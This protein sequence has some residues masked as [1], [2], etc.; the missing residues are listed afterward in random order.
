MQSQ[1]KHLL[2]AILLAWI[3]CAVL[4]GQSHKSLRLEVSDADRA[5]LRLQDKAREHTRFS[6]PL[7]LDLA[8]A[9]APDTY[10]FENGEWTWSHTFTVS[11]AT[12]LGLFLDRLDLPVGGHLSLANAYGRKGAFT[13]VDASYKNRLFTDF[14]PGESVTLT[15]RGPLPETVPFRIWRIDH[16]YRPDRWRDPRDKGFGDSN[17]CHVNANCDQGDGWDDEQSGAARINLVVTEGV[18]FCSGSLINNTAMDGRPFLLTGFHCMDGFTPL[19]DLWAIDFDYTG[20]G[21]E[22]PAEEPAPTRYIGVE[23][24]AGL[25]ATDFLLLEITD[26]TFVAEDHFFAGWDRSPGDVSGPITHFH[27]PFGDVQ[28]IGVSV[29]EGMTVLT[30]QITWNSDVVTPPRH[31]FVLDYAVGT[32]QQGSSGSVYFDQDHRI[33]GTLNGG[34]AN[35]PGPSEAF[36]GRFH[37]SWETGM[38]DSARLRP[39]LD[40]LGTNPMTLDGANLVT[41]RFVSG[42]VTLEGQ[43]V[44]GATI[45]FQW[46][47]TGRVEYTT[48]ADGFYRGVRPQNVSAFGVS[49][50]YER[51]EPALELAVDVSDLISVRR[52]LLNLNPLSPERRLAADVNNTGTVRVSDITLMTRVILNVTDWRGRPNWLVVPVGYSLN[53]LPARPFEPIGISLNSRAV[54][55]LSIDFFVLKT[56]DANGD[57][58]Q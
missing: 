58:G 33:R 27:H 31:H 5:E 4:P 18:G 13:Q 16:V 36:V 19:Y 30:D 54:H 23:Q 21:C 17:E 52:H 42:R 38:A 8:P 41:Q 6:A 48:D 37:L 2:P 28:K 40:P 9:T 14:L 49:G 43:P 12:G 25:Q 47:P 20:T 39:W 1:K 22:D 7:D 3:C 32:F 57:V 56:G 35:C 45:V 11:G 26:T 10:D 53:P 44:E 24:R 15:Y 55:E 50:T 34:N 51:D 46:P 29:P